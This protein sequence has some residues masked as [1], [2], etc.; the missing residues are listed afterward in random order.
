MKIKI[1]A[2]GKIKEQ[3]FKDAICEYLK[4][5]SR[6]AEI[7][8]IEI[9]D[10]S[11]ADRPSQKEIEKAKDIEAQ[12]V[13]KK[14]KN[15]EHV[16]LLDLGQKE[17]ESPQFAVFLERKFID[18]GGKLLFVIGGSYG[19]GEALKK[20]SNDSISLAKMTF[21]HQM[22]RIIFLEQLYRAFKILNNE[23]YHK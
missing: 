12:K 16:I 8:I 7:E 6:F 4:R 17:L 1:L 14:I 22:S 13:L 15:D 11:V 5:L 9:N 3:Y 19:L 21:T 20:R 10:Q 18:N 23:V 2:V